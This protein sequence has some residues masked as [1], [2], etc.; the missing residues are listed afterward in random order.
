MVTDTIDYITLASL[1]NAIDFGKLSTVRTNIG[2]AANHRRGLFTGGSPVYPSTVNIIE[3]VKL[4]PRGDAQD[5]GDLVDL[6]RGGTAVSDSHG[7]LGGY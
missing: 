6:K 2:G 5:F 7:G 1:G 4:Q 3:F